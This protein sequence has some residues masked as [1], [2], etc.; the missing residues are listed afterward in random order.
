MQTREVIG[1]NNLASFLIACRD[2]SIARSLH[3]SLNSAFFYD[4]F[5]LWKVFLV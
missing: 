4:T 2:S 3:P 5:I 1:S